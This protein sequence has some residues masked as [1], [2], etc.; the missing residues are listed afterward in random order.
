[1]SGGVNNER[2]TL[3]QK[4]TVTFNIIL[5]FDLIYIICPS[6]TSDTYQPVRVY[7]T[8]VCTIF[9]TTVMIATRVKT[10]KWKQIIFVTTSPSKSTDDMLILKFRKHLKSIIFSPNTKQKFIC[11]TPSFCCWPVAAKFKGQS[12]SR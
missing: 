11:L 12:V 8:E 9:R 6:L 3:K 4:C 2:L 7:Y 5:D 1:M 10:N